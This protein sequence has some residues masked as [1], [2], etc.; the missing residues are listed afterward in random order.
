MEWQANALAPRIQ[1]PLAMFKRQAF[2]MIQKYRDELGVFELCELMPFVIDELADFFMVSR[3]AAKLRMIDVGYEEAAGAFIY[4]DGHYVKPHAYKKG[5]IKHN[6]TYSIPAQDAAIQSIINPKLKDADYYVYIDSHFVLNH[7]RY[8]YQNEAG[9]TLMTDYA[10]YHVDECCL[11]FD[12]SIRGRI[13]ERYHR[14]CFLNRDTV[15]EEAR[16]LVFPTTTR[17]HGKNC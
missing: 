17:K 9:E 13:E 15:K 14:E 3:T 5:S 1:V 11:A 2:A 4:I 8:V 10:R 12:L 6:H 16:V 7:P